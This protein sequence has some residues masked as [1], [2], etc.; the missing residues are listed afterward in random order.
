VHEVAGLV[1]KP[2]A[3]RIVRAGRAERVGHGPA[4]YFEVDGA[5]EARGACASDAGRALR[6]S[7]RERDQRHEREL[8]GREREAVR[9]GP[10]SERRLAGAGGGWEEERAA[11][12]LDERAVEQEPRVAVVGEGEGDVLPEPAT[13][14]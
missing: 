14:A 6:A 5:R 10:G 11:A 9:D 1:P 7:V 13:G 4:A 12:A 2:V 8:V 3:A